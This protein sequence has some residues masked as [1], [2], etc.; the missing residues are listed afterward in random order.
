MPTYRNEKYGFEIDLPEGWS[1]SSGITRIPV[2]L[3]NVIKRANILEEFSSGSDEHLNIVVEPMEPE[4]PPDINELI[5]TLQAQDMKYT[6]VEFGRITIGGRLH[7]WVRYTMKSK[8]WLKKYFI[9]LNGNGYAITANCATK[10]KLPV[11]EKTWDGIAESLRLLKP[12]DESITALNNSPGARRTIEMARK[13]LQ[14]Q[15]EERKQK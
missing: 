9:V 4:P 11:S 3:S 8:V 1:I 12:V 10:D 2:I 14:I 5:F 15:I 6:D 13:M 7:A